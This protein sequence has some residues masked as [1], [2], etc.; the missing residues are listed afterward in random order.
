MTT[1]VVSL[2]ELRVGDADRVGGKAANLGELMQTGATVPAGFAITSAGFRHYIQATGLDSTLAKFTSAIDFADLM[3]V[4]YI[5]SRCRQ[6]IKATALPNALASMIEGFYGT[7]EISNV[8]AVRSSALGEDSG[9]AS[10]AGQHSTY[11]GV[12]GITNLHSRIRDCFAS[13]YEP[14]ALA[15]RAEQGISISGLQMAVVVQSIVSP[16]SSGVLFTRDPN[17]GEDRSINR[18]CLGVG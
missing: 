4:N 5:A 9:S 17:T 8:V 11:L 3:R 6:V 13:L 7:E 12:E 2:Q 16:D 14:R 18:G 10:F 1:R 15:Y